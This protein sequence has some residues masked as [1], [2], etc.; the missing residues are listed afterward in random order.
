MKAAIYR[1]FGAPLAIEEVPDPSPAP[2]GVVIRVEATGICR[3]DWHGWM[4]HD[5]D[6]HLPHVP[7]HELAGVVAAVGSEVR[8]WRGGERVTM[9][10]AM[11][12]G[13]CPQCAAGDQHI[14][15]NYFQPGFTGWG[16][17][18]P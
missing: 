1:A 7:G 18:A 9:P 2:D 17:V 12:C 6:V 5:S 11:G 8:R 4:G 13:T 14:C 10:F 15:D 16:S 3:S